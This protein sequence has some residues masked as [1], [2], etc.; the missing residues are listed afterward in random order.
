MAGADI[1][2]SILEELMLIGGCDAFEFTWSISLT[3]KWDLIFGE[4]LEMVSTS[5]EEEN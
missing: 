5:K 4:I 3:S 1:S 2:L